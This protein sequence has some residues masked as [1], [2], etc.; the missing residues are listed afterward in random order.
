[1]ELP[2]CDIPESVLLQL[3]VEDALLSSADSEPV[4]ILLDEA[5]SDLSADP[6]ADIVPEHRTDDRGEYRED[7]VIA[8]PE[9]SDEEHDVHPW[10]CCPDDRK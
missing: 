8:C 7:E 3:L 1:M 9:P 6:V 2:E 5:R 4:S 10:N